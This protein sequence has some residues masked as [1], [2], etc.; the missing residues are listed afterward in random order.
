MSYS[1]LVEAQ[2]SGIPHAALWHCLVDV[3]E[4]RS[5]LESLDTGDNLV[6]HNAHRRIRGLRAVESVQDNLLEATWF[7]AFAYKALDSPRQRTWPN[8]HYVGAAVPRSPQSSH[9][10]AR[11]RAPLVV[12]GF[13][14]TSIDQTATCSGCSTAWRR[15]TSGSWPP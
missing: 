4:K 7:L 6:S 3:A 11:G 9:E 13:S 5:N 12:V 14:T 8:L 10:I 2:A 1:A 15:S